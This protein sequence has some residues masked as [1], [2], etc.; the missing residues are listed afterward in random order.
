MLIE[1][2]R[3]DLFPLSG[4]LLLVWAYFLAYRDPLK[5]SSR[6]YIWMNIFGAGILA[7]FA[8]YRVEPMFFVI[9]FF[10]MIISILS[11]IRMMRRRG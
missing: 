8:I 11:L 2:L 1:L 10:W 7:A 9:E 3:E 6:I 5:Q 4:M